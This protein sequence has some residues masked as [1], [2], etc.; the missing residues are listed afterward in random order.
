MGWSWKIPS[1]F[2]INKYKLSNMIRYVLYLENIQN[3]PEHKIKFL[4]ESHIV[5]KDLTK[6]KVL[7]LKCR[8]VF[9][10]ENTLNQ[11]H[12]SLTSLTSTVEHL[13]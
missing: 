9:V 4:D 3:I 13:Y 12:A 11:K 8:R 1:K 2:Q 7:G 6:R 5:S 10:K